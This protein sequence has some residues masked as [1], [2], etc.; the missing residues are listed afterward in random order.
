MLSAAKLLKKVEEETMSHDERM[1]SGNW[2]SRR[3]AIYTQS[4]AKSAC[5]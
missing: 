3:Q 5:H 1:L 4:A 2:H